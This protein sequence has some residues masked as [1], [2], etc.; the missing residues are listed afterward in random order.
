M[1]LPAEDRVRLR[2][3]SLLHDVGKMAVPATVLNKA[4]P[5]ED[6]EWHTLRQHPIEGAKLTVALAPWLGEWAATIEQHHERWD[7]KGYPHGLAGTQIHQGARI[8]AVADSY[9]VMTAT[10]AYKKP[11][12]PAV[13]RR[14]LAADAGAQF[15]P[16]VVRAFLNISLGRLRMAAGPLT[17]LAQIPFL[18]PVAALSRGPVPVALGGT[19]AAAV[20]SLALPSTATPSPHVA[21]AHHP[22]PQVLGLVATPTAPIELARSLPPAS[23]PAAPSATP[24]SRSGAT[25]PVSGDPPPLATVGSPAPAPVP[26]PPPT[27][28]VPEPPPSAPEPQ[29]TPTSLVLVTV[30]VGDPVD[31]ELAAAVGEPDA[32]PVPVEPVEVHLSVP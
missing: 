30:H 29:P 31:T 6:H 9:E 19:L 26:T 3:A 8:V 15:D 11:V 4:D 23:A 1:H 10:R 27:G 24:A 21:Q 2:W 22:A 32:L 13:A 5:L 7:G 17:W 14:R 16:D 12:S 28:P 20:V 25:P 18:R